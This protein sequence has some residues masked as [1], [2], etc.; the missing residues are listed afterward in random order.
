MNWV[1][2]YSSLHFV[3]KGLT[4]GYTYIQTHIHINIV[5]TSKNMQRYKT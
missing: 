4:M 3:F 2:K 1:F 5:A